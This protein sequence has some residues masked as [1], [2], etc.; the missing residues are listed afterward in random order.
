MATSFIMIPDGTV[1]TST[2]TAKA[3]GNAEYTNVDND[4]GDTDYAYTNTNAQRMT[5][6]LASPSVSEAEIA[7]INTVTIKA[8]ASKT[9]SGNSLVKFYMMGTDGDSGTIASGPDTIT[10]T[11]GPGYATITGPDE[12]TPNSGDWV[13]GDLSGLQI[14]A[15]KFRNDRFGQLRISYFY[16]VVDYEAAAADNAIF[17]GANF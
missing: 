16:V 4:D 2:W 7:S 1:G 6:N 15:E 3:G 10:V 13:Y 14:R 12:T 8:S 9:L 11:S 5:F 17:F